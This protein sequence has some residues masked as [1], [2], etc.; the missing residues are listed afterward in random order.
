MDDRNTLNL[1]PE[2]PVRALNAGLFV[3]RGQGVHATRTIE[4]HELIFVR[5]GVLGM[6]EEDRR[7]EVRAGEALHLWP[8]RRHGGTAP[9]PADL[10]FYWLHF[11]TA[12]RGRQI[13]RSATALVLPQHARVGRPDRLTE[14]LRR[15]LDDQESGRLTPL[16]GALL[17]TLMLEEASGAGSPA[18]AASAAASGAEALAARADEFILTHFHEPVSAWDVAGNLDCNPDYLGRVYRRMR[19]M[20]L[21]EAINRA[22]LRHARKLL[23]DS[24]RNI[25]EVARSAGFSEAGYFRRV[26]QRAEGL[27]PSAFRRS[28]ARMHMN[29]E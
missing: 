14:L 24:S 11:R 25:D 6:F 20:T 18:A 15:F 5:S 13:G 3:S 8:G 1:D 26:F 12:Q 23:L 29:T 19:R 28:Y 21:T 22:R 10:S 9:Y 16:S 27:T 2:L 7:F 4:S 17:V